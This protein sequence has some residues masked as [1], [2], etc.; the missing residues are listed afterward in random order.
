MS[1]FVLLC[2]ISFL[3][4]VVATAVCPGPPR[5]EFA[6]VQLEKRVYEPGEEVTYACQPGYIHASGSRRA[7]CTNSG[8]W[9]GVAF[10]CILKTCTYPGPLHNGE[11][12]HTELTYQSVISFSCNEGY[13]LK[14]ADSS[15]CTERAEWTEELPVCEPVTCPFPPVPESGEIIFHLPRK[16]NLSIFQ[17]VVRYAC[18]PNYALFGN[19]TVSCLAN[20]NWSD[21]PECKDVQCPRPTGIENG[22]MNFHLKKSFHYME[23][24]S[25]GCSPNYVLDGPRDSRCEKTGNW[26][27]KPSC[28]EYNSFTALFVTEASSMKECI[29]MH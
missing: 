24:V 11:I 18:L 8:R 17:D 29:A 9:S 7:V 3:H 1:Y 16:G 26:S 25:Y 4:G 27:I 2:G 6:S 5:V 14:G 19:E 21:F 28:K 20:G 22:F 15:Q 10:R 12:Y 13:I 23:K